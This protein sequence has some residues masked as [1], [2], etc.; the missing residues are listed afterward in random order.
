[1]TASSWSHGQDSSLRPG[2]DSAV[3]DPLIGPV[4]GYAETKWLGKTRPMQE[5]K[6]KSIHDGYDHKID[7]ICDV[8]IQS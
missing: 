1:M 2:Q 5:I 6:Y 7:G 3:K 4:A 8:N